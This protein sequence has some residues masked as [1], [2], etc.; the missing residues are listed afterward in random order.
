MPTTTHPPAF[1]PFIFQVWP[2]SPANTAADMFPSRQRQF[3]DIPAHC[4]V[5]LPVPLLRHILALLPEDLAQEV[6]CYATDDYQE[7][8]A[9]VITYEMHRQGY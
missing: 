1:Q 6:V 9:P 5:G 8:T 4:V 2:E 3:E 7:R